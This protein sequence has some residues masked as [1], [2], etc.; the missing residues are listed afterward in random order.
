MIIRNSIFP[1]GPSGRTEHRRRQCRAEEWRCFVQ[2]I[3]AVQI[4]IAIV[5]KRRLT[6]IDRR[7]VDDRR[8]RRDGSG[9]ARRRR[10]RG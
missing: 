10:C 2:F 7:I 9:R 3:I 8:G 4:V 1:T 6:L 5:V